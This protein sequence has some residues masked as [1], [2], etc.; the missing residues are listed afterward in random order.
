MNREECEA[1]FARLSEYLDGDLAPADCETLEAHVRD[2][3]P[4]VEFIESLRKSV[5]LG[6]QYQPEESPSPL[7][8]EIRAR[9]KALF[10]ETGSSK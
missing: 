9:L 4:C 3:A 2:C 5:R 10:R 8:E 6:R 7:T 1:V